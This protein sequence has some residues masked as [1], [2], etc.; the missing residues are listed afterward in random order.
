MKDYRFLYCLVSCFLIISCA[1]TPVDQHPR[2]I[3]NAQSFYPQRNYLTAVGQSSKLDLA[4]KNAIANLA[5]IAYIHIRAESHT[6]TEAA[7]AES[8]LGV[9]LESSTSVQRNINTKTEQALSGVTIRESW[10]SP[11]GEYYALAVLGKRAAASSLNESI[12]EL[13]NNTNKLIEYSR[14]TAPN[15]IVSL[16]ALR[17]ARDDQLARQVANMQLKQVSQSGIPADISSKQIERLIDQKLASMQV[18]VNISAEKHAKTV[19]SGLSRLGIMVVENAN[20]EVSADYD[21]TEP[22]LMDGWYWMRG[23][24]EL[25]I[26]ENGQVI[27]RKRWPVKVSAQQKEVM[28]SRLKDGISAN[29]SQYLIELVS[30]SPSL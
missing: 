21:I 27:S 26:S 16:N 15:S 25:S 3:D 10:L 7:K 17:D 8:A 20:I 24:Y 28:E 5:E 12:I 4:G 11:D 22:T 9:T 23:S 14:T 18:A 2:W 19:Q 1:S 29:M 6:L 30:D 13:D